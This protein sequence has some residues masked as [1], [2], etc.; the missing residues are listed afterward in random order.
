MHGKKKRHEPSKKDEKPRRKQIKQRGRATVKS[1][2]RNLDDNWEMISE[3]FM[4]GDN[5]ES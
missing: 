2:L 3:R 5:N 4:K 1:R